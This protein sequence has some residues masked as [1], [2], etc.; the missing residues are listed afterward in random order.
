MRVVVGVHVLVAGVGRLVARV[1]R[2]VV[3]ARVLVAGVGDFFQ[4]NCPRLQ[5]KVGFF[6]AVPSL[7]MR[8]AIG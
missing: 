3:G 6:G 2:V 7:E 1:D 4:C 8:W 5:F